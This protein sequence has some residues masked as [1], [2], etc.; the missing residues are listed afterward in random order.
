MTHS[1]RSIVIPESLN[2]GEDSRKNLQKEM[3]LRSSTIISEE[4]LFQYGI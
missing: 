3:I 1:G 4:G 2:S